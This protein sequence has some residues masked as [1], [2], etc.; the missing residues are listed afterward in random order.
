M[1]AEKVEA[2][3][4]IYNQKNNVFDGKPQINIYLFKRTVPLI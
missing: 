1:T 4:D 3:F 2:T